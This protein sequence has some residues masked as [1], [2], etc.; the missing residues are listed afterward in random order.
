MRNTSGCAASI[1]RLYYSVKIVDYEDVTYLAGIL[2][3]WAIAEMTCGI[4]AMCLP[5]SPKFFKRLQAA[6]FWSSL[7]TS[8]HS[9]TRSKIEPTSETPTDENVVAKLDSGSSSLK[10]YFRK[11]HYVTANENEIELGSVSS[12][13]GVDRT[14]RAGHG[15]EAA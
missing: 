7:R 3:L 10:A 15:M 2:Y 11:Y 8:L 13:G 1:V 6:K 14:V 9:L 4:L 12:Q 5:I